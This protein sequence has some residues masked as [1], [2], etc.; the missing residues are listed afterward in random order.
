MFFHTLTDLQSIHVVECPEFRR[1]CMVLCET[2]IDTDIPHRNKMRE[3]I[4][5]QWWD[6]FGRLKLDLSVGIH[7]L[8][9]HFIYHLQS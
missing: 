8:S 5:S 3:A 6:S 9:F 4:I 1:L 7:I 2:L